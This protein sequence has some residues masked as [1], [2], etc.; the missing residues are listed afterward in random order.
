MILEDQDFIS[1]QYHDARKGSWIT[2][3]PFRKTN[4][5]QQELG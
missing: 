4:S 1:P 2:N 3:E 5:L